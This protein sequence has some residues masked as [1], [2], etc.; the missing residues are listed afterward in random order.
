MVQVVLEFIM[1]MKLASSEL[2]GLKVCDI[3]ANL[4]LFIHE[5][6]T[7]DH[8]RHPSAMSCLLDQLS[9]DMKVVSSELFQGYF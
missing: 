9:M 2:G 3:R 8:A 7:S 1:A 5:Y 4:V 6:H